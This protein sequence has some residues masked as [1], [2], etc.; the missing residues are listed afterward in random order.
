MI[1]VSMDSEMHDSQSQPISVHH[2]NWGRINAL[3]DKEIDRS[4][5]T[6]QTKAFLKRALLKLPESKTAVTIRPDRTIVNWL[7]TKWPGY[8]TRINALLLAYMKTLS[9]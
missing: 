8:L 9:S 2:M 7:K 3:W 4:E 1:L 6:E 5:I